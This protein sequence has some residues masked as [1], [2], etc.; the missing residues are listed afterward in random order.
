MPPT[1]QPIIDVNS[2]PDFP[3]QYTFRGER[4]TSSRSR[5][6]TRLDPKNSRARTSLARVREQNL[7]ASTGQ[8]K[9]CRAFR[10]KIESNFEFER[11]RRSGRD[12]VVPISNHHIPSSLPATG[13]VP[14]RICGLLAGLF[15]AIW[16][17]R[18]ALT[19]HEPEETGFLNQK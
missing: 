13:S 6:V 12:S 15:H 14:C 16:N 7:R 9:I 8:R 2:I 18:Q 17:C 4:K 5:T 10:R 1:F 19:C 3:T 11:A